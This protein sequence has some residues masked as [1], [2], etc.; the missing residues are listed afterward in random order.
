MLIGVAVTSAAW[1][2]TA[3][4]MVGVGSAILGAFGRRL[5]RTDTVVAAFWLGWAAT[6]AL[7]QVWHVWLPVGPAASL[8]VGA[9]ALVGYWTQRRELARLPGRIRAGW[10][11]ASSRDRL[12]VAGIALLVLWL[13]NRAM[14]PI[15]PQGD[16]GLYHVGAIRWLQAHP[17]LPGLGNVDTKFAFNNAH[18]LY[19]ALVDFAPGPPHFHHVGT[20][21]LFV[22]W[23]AQLIGH[24]RGLG[25]RGA[26]AEGRHVLGALCTAAIVPYLFMEFGTTSTDTVNL[27]IGFVLGTHLFRL[28][29]ERDAPRDALLDWLVVLALATVGVTVKLSF[30][31]VG[32]AAVA[33]ASVGLVMRRMAETRARGLG[34]VRADLLPLL[35]AAGVA[36]LVLATW[37]ARGVITGG[38]LAYPA[39]ATLAFPVDWRIPESLLV[40]ESESIRVWAR[41]PFHHELSARD[42]ILGGWSWI[43][44]WLRKTAERADA[45]TIP[46][47]LFVAGVFAHLRHGRTGRRALAGPLLFLAPWVIGFV[48]WFF[49]APAERFGGAIFWMLGAGAWATFYSAVPSDFVRA[50]LARAARIFVATTVVATAIVGAVLSHGRY[51]WALFVTPGPEDGF[52]PIPTVQV[53]RVESTS[54]FAYNVPVAMGPPTSRWKPG[55]AC[56]DAPLP[57]RSFEQPALALRDRASIRHG[58]RLAAPE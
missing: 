50:R 11:A 3:L 39:S 14:A 55:I 41:Y 33:S 47:L 1:A 29:S 20:P 30:V 8:F 25:V 31:V 2:T 32:A 7:L 28:C 38:Y 37:A 48:F 34:A 49:T 22:V 13:A 5:E 42:E 27:L 40:V 44:P 57:C 21:V 26:P 23:I 51:G 19:M 24:V 4:L 10:A 54:G 18:F 52:H 17:L 15:T 45:F 9:L 16:S 43:G 58:F 53:Q 46:M 35:V 36:A 56:W 12:F 6:I